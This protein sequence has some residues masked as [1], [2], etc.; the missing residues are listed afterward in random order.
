[1]DLGFWNEGRTGERDGRCGKRAGNGLFI[2]KSKEI[3]R[4]RG[5]ESRGYLKNIF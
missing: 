2:L 5:F 1:L 4:W 3:R